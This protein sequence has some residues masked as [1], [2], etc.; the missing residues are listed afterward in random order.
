MNR[1]EFLPIENLDGP[2]QDALFNKGFFTVGTIVDKLP[3]R[4]S[5]SGKPFSI[6]RISDI[7]KFDMTKVKQHLEKTY[8]KD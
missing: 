8:R 5:K 1:R 3:I 6:F 7:Q 4:T 2:N